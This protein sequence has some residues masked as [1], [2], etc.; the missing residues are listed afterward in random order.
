MT[1]FGL[2]T[3]DGS[4]ARHKISNASFLG[5][6]DRSRPT[7]LVRA[8]IGALAFVLA[9]SL[10]APL[11]ASAS[12]P[13]PAFAGPGQAPTSAGRV[14]IGRK[15]ANC[16]VLHRRYPHGVGRRGARDHVSG[17]SKPVTTFTRNNVAYNANRGLDR[18]K[19][20]IA[21]EKR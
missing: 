18:D 2:T 7:T 12:S 8:A 16:A 6:L 14:A 5:I 4:T 13:S 11:A 21:C 19:D 20:G 3:P 17:S 1:N 10:A 15:Y 9:L